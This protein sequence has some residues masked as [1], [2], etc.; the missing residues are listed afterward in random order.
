MER[1]G[2]RGGWE[3]VVVVGLGTLCSTGGVNGVSKSGWVMS[4]GGGGREVPS[5]EDMVMAEGVWS[6]CVVG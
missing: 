3:G 1:S 5:Y 4:L 6:E 2:R